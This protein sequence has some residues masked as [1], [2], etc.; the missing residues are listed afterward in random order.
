MLY[1]Y[2][3]NSTR[4]VDCIMDSFQNAS[5]LHDP[6]YGSQV[7]QN[8]WT[9]GIHLDNYLRFM[10]NGTTLY[11]RK[12]TKSDS[13]PIE[14]YERQF[15]EIEFLRKQSRLL[16]CN[17]VTQVSKEHKFESLIVIHWIMSRVFPEQLLILLLIKPLISFVQV[18]LLVMY[19]VLYTLRCPD[20]VLNIVSILQLVSLAH[21]AAVLKLIIFGQY[22]V[23]L[24]LRF[25]DLFDIPRDYP[26]M[27]WMNWETAHSKTFVP[28]DVKILDSELSPPQLRE[29]SSFSIMCYVAF[30]AFAHLFTLVR[31]II[32]KMCGV[33][34]PK[35]STTSQLNSGKDGKPAGETNAKSSTSESK[36]ESS[37]SESEMES[38]TSESANVSDSATKSPNDHAIT[39]DEIEI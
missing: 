10:E 11:L 29:V 33:K 16:F 34:S 8:C 24:G 15:D 30:L 9:Y 35:N 20:A 14:F 17:G 37:T 27:G 5:H 25:E 2:L 38:S 39:M 26:T 28:Q 36:M 3:T 6:V 18:V 4:T 19:L 1:F 31:M 21:L 22:S 7:T 12:H 13:R 32:L 23:V